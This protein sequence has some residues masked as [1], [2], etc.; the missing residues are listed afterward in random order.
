MI[1]ARGIDEEVD[2]VARALVDARD[3]DSWLPLANQSRLTRELNL[4]RVRFDS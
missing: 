2:L 1:K 4:K 3:S